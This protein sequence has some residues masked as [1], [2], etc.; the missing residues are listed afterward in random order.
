[1]YFCSW[2]WGMLVP[3]HPLSPD[4]PLSSGMLG[5]LA[6]PLLSNHVIFIST[7]KPCTVV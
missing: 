7:I 4:V 2:P 1:M 6:V 5:T 3:P